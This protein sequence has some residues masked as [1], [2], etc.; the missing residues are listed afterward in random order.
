MI[1]KRKG[2][3]LEARTF[4]GKSGQTYLVFKTLDKGFHVFVEI[5]AKEAADDC[6]TKHKGTRRGWRWLWANSN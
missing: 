2:F 4:T 6:G 3:G 5:E 1:K